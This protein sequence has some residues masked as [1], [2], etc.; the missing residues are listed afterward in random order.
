[1]AQAPEI[2]NAWRDIDY[3]FNDGQI[4]HAWEYSSPKPPG[5]SYL[6]RQVTWTPYCRGAP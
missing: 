4:M 3:V 6:V 1:M 5:S 2:Q